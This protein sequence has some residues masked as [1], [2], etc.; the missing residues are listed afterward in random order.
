MGED[1]PSR[2]K[3]KCKGPKA[4]TYLVVEEQHGSK[5]TN[6]AKAELANENRGRR[7]HNEDL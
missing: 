5:E 1:C 6:V 7:G 3:S 2:G 4:G